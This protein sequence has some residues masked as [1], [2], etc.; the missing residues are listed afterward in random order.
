MRKSILAILF[1]VI[2]TGCGKS[3]DVELM[4]S[5]LVRTGM[6]Q[7]QAD[8]FAEK[9]S[10]TVK[11]EPY[12]YMAALMKEGMDE[13]GAVNKTR[14]KYTAEFTTPMREARKACVQ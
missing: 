3:P 1:L 6:P 14:R 11:G 9:M 5:G 13:R 8:C 2:L 4:I 7:G 12:N 10:K